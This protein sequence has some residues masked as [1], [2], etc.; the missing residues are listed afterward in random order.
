MNADKIRILNPRSSVFSKASWDLCPCR[1]SETVDLASAAASAV[2]SAVR[3]IQPVAAVVVRVV[4]V[5]AERLHV[6]V[7]VFVAR[8]TRLVRLVAVVVAPVVLRVQLA[9]QLLPVPLVAVR[10]VAGA[11]VARRG[12]VR[13]VCPLTHVAVELVELAVEEQRVVKPLAVPRVPAVRLSP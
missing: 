7:R 5:A 8:V 6:V 3:V 9:A 2:A 4:P 1:H 12:V 11:A 13:V 10:S